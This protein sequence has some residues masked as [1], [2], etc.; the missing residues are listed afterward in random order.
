MKYSIFHTSQCGS[1]LLATLLK[2]NKKT[3]AEPPWSGRMDMKDILSAEDNTLVKYPSFT[4]L[5]CRI[6]P[7][8]K[9]FIFRSL[10]D[11]L[12]KITNTPAAMKQHLSFHYNFFKNIRNLFPDLVVDSDLKKLAFVWANIYLDVHHSP[13]VLFIN[14]NDLFLDSVVT[15]EKITNFFDMDPV[16]DLEPLNFYVKNDFLATEKALNNINPIEKIPFNVKEGYINSNRFSS[17]D[18]WVEENIFEKINSNE[19]FPLFRR[20][21]G[22]P[23]YSFVPGKTYVIIDPL[24]L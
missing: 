14:A 7:G 11:H 24:T 4:S 2:N 8:K 9:V 15:L 10:Q 22:S 3:Y 17:V 20:K 21:N 12:E 5:A 1:T 13:N 19:I 6:I 23:V 18:T 16:K